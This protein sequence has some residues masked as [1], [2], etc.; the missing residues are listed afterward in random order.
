MKSGKREEGA[1]GQDGL[2]GESS[3]RLLRRARFGDG[4]ALD[5]LYS[6]YL[7]PLRNWARGRLPDWARGMMDTDDLVQDVLLQTIR[8]LDGFD[9]QHSGA[10]Q[11]YVRRGILNRMRDEIR[12]A[13]RRPQQDGSLS[14][15][16]DPAPSP[17]EQAIGSETLQRF[18][19]ALKKLSPTDQEA[20]L[21]RIEL[22][23]SYAELA[24][25][26]GKPS[27][28]AARMTVK[29]ALFRLA[30]EMADEQT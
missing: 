19:K 23:M 5:C 21:G 10:F 2:D 29:R 14:E 9:P 12:K 1:L 18:E 15:M 27:P 3:I 7:P 11:G 13:Q 22:G 24:Q 30:Q 20:I 25:S 28:D 17:V 4:E 8:V 6:R 16:I 26:L